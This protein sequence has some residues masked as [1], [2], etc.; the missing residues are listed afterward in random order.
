MVHILKMFVCD[1]L[2]PTTTELGDTRE[3]FAI[4]VGN[5][6]QLKLEHRFRKTLYLYTYV[7]T[8]KSDIGKLLLLLGG[9]F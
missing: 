6:I 2:S 8:M 9:C 3:M 1:Y 7:H 4:Q 5:Y